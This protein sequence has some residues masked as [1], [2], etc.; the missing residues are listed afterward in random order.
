MLGGLENEKENNNYRLGT[1][2][3]F[4]GCYL[5][6]E[7]AVWNL[8]HKAPELVNN[9]YKM[10]VQF[11]PENGRLDLRNF[12]GQKKKRTAFFNSDT[13]KQL[14]TALIDRV[15]KY[16]ISGRIKRL[17]HHKFRTLLLNENVCCGCVIADRYSQDFSPLKVTE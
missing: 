4:C 8:T 15:R 12:G 1:F 2:R 10:G 6:D 3:T 9:L 16:E 5:A 17:S 14:M 7:Q 11:N 13:G